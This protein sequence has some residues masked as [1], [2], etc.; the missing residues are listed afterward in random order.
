MLH[1]SRDDGNARRTEGFAQGGRPE[2]IRLPDDRVSRGGELAPC[3]EERCV[4]ELAP[5]VHAVEAR[6]RLVAGILGDPRPA[7]E[8]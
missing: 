3:D 2:L 5:D 4:G 7:A 8:P 6:T 1:P